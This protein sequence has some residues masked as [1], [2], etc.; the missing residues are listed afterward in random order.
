MPLNLCPATRH[1][2]NRLVEM[3]T[4]HGHV[5]ALLPAMDPLAGLGDRPTPQLPSGGDD[6]W[7]ALFEQLVLSI[8]KT[9]TMKKRLNA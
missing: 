8:E 1:S 2:K 6:A 9:N 3:A 5:P 4:L 7:V